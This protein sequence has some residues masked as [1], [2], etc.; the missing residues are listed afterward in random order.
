MLPIEPYTRQQVVHSWKSHTAHT[1]QRLGVIHGQVW[2]EE[3]FDRIVRDESELRRFHDYILNN[4][5]AA[6]LPAGKF[7]VGEGTAPWLA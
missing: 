1:L 5:A 7:I 3:C 2:Q 6:H 4:P